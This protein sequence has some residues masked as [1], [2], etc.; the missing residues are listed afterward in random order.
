M[1]SSTVAIATILISRTLVDDLTLQFLY[2]F[3][4]TARSLQ[5]EAG[6]G[7]EQLS[8]DHLALQQKNTVPRDTNE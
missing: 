2:A 8:L 5:E 7:E 4:G 1:H 3:E 6:A